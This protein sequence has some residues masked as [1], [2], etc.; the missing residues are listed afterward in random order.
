MWELPGDAEGRVPTPSP[1]ERQS[2]R[3][4]QLIRREWI[5]GVARL[6][7]H[8]PPPDVPRHGWRQFVDDCNAFLNSPEAERAAELGWRTIALFGCK[9]SYPLSYLREAGLLWHVNGGRII[10]LHRDWAVID[11]PVNRSPRRPQPPS[12]LSSTR[13]P[14]ALTAHEVQV[15]H[16]ADQP[17]SC[18]HARRIQI[19]SLL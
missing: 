14:F 19:P 2:V 8:R 9:P 1:V 5:E 12:S 17:A 18:N 3:K 11:G 7:Q 15:A 16:W 6:E 10:E 13:A 4:E